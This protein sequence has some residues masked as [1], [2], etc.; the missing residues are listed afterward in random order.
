MLKIKEQTE[1]QY[2]E[3]MCEKYNIEDRKEY[4]VITIDPK[5]S[6][7][8][9]DAIGYFNENSISIISVYITN[10]SLWMEIM[11][12]WESFSERI[13]TIYLPDRK[14]PML[15]TILSDCI[16]SLKEKC[17]RVAFTMDIYIKDGEIIDTKFSNTLICV[18]KNYVYDEISLDENTMFNN[19]L[20]TLK[21]I[22]KKYKYL[23]NMKNSHDVITYLMI[24]MNYHCAKSMVMFENG[25]Y[26][27]VHLSN[28]QIDEKIEHLPEKVSGFLKVWNSSSGQYVEFSNILNHELLDLESYIHITSPIRRLVDLLNII[29]L[30]KNLKMIKYSDSC[31]NFY[32]KWVSKLDYI[33][34]TMRIIR[35][36]QNDCELLQ[37]CSN[38]TEEIMNKIYDGYIFDRVL[39]SDNIYQ[40]IIYIPDV[41]MTTRLTTCD[42]LN[43]YDKYYFKL[44]MFNDEY[45]LKRKIRLQLIEK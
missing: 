13:S 21:T 24:L 15:P 6:Q 36:V 25:I 7:D 1:E 8:F 14:R 41:S 31:N 9:D 4:E 16:C 11:D 10:V 20:L 2:I 37:L 43:I 22:Y 33:N 26:R 44:F 38:N 45:M 39:R 34:S 42:E 28:K 17:K 23:H 3:K 29:Q 18:S 19:I 32:N 12:L 5:G 27:S 35:K 40:Y 30:M